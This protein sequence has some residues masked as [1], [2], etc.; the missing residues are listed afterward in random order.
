MVDGR[1][2]HTQEVRH[3][4]QSTTDGFLDRG[5]RI[6]RNNHQVEGQDG[7][8][9]GWWLVIGEQGGSERKYVEREGLEESSE[10]GGALKRA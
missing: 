1:S 5:D 10:D 2:R 7:N 9:G 8:R 3:P 4:W 6:L